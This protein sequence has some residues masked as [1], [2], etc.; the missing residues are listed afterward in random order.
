MVKDLFA[1]SKYAVDSKESDINTHSFV[2][3]VDLEIIEN[4]LQQC[5]LYCFITLQFQNPIQD[6]FLIN[7]IDF[8]IMLLDQNSQVLEQYNNVNE[9]TS[10]QVDIHIPLKQKMDKLFLKLK[11]IDNGINQQQISLIQDTFQTVYARIENTKKEEFYLQRH[12]QLILTCPKGQFENNGFCIEC[13]SCSI[14]NS[15]ST[16]SAQ[17]ECFLCLSLPPYGLT[18]RLDGSCQKDCPPGLSYNVWD[19]Q[20][21]IGCDQS[22][23]VCKDSKCVSC[24]NNSYMIYPDFNTCYL[25]QNGSTQIGNLCFKCNLNQFI[26]L[27]NKKCSS[28]DIYGPC[29]KCDQNQCLKCSPS[30]CFDGF[31]QKKCIYPSNEILKIGDFCFKKSSS[32]KSYSQQSLREDKKQI[33]CDQCVNSKYI[34]YYDGSCQ[35]TCK[36]WHEVFDGVCMQCNY[37]C[38][39]CPKIYECNRCEKDR[40]VVEDISAC[41]K[42][43][44]CLEMPGHFINKISKT[45]DVCKIDKGYYYS[46][47]QCK[48]C[49]SSCK[50]CSGGQYNQCLTCFEGSTLLDDKTCF[51]CTINDGKYIDDSKNCKQCHYSCKTCNGGSELNCLTCKGN[52]ILDNQSKRCVC[53]LSNCIECSLDGFSCLKCK[54]GYVGRDCSECNIAQGKYIFNN[55]CKSCDSSCQTCSGPLKTDCIDCKIQAFKVD[56]INKLCQCT[57]ENCQ[58][59][60]LDGIECIKCIDGYTLK[61]KKCTFCDIQNGYFISPE[62]ICQECHSS[63]MKCNGPYENNCEQCKQSG[64]ILD[65]MS[66]KCICKFKNCLECSIDGLHCQKCIENYTIRNNECIYCDLYNGYYLEN[67]VC[68]KCDESCSSCTGPTKY[69]CIRCAWGNYILDPK[70]SLCICGIQNCKT[71]SVMSCAECI[72]DFVLIDNKC[73]FCDLS[74]SKFIL[75]NNCYQCH[76]S[77]KTCHGPTER[78]CDTCLI[79]L[80]ERDPNNNNICSCTI[81]NCKSC[82]SDG[83]KCLECQEFYVNQQNF[84]Q[85]CDEKKGYQFNKISNQCEKCHESCKTCFGTQKTEC[86][87]CIKPNYKPNLSNMNIC[88]CALQNCKMCDEDGI[89]CLQCQM[90]YYQVNG[91]CQYCDISQFN[92]DQFNQKC[93]KCHASCSTCNGPTER[94]CIKCLNDNFVQDPLNFNICNCK[95]KNCQ[96]CSIDGAF[97]QKCSEN[98]YLSNSKTECFQCDI[99]NQFF[100]DKQENTCLSCHGDCKT[101]SGTQKNECLSCLHKGQF[102]NESNFCVCPQN[103]CLKCE[104]EEITSKKICQCEQCQCD[105]ENCEQC[106]SQDEETC[107]V[108]KPNFILIENGKVCQKQKYCKVE[109]CLQCSLNSDKICLKCQ[110]GFFLSENNRF[111]DL[112]FNEINLSQQFHLNMQLTDEGYK[113]ILQFEKPLLIR[114]ENNFDQII[115]VQITQI[116]REDY[117][118]KIKKA[119]EKQL[120]IHLMLNVTCKEERGILKIKDEGFIQLNYLSKTEETVVLENFVKLNQNQKEQQKNI[121]VASQSITSTVVG[122]VI[123]LALLGNF[124]I[125]FSMLDITGLIYYLLY[126]DI[127]YPFNVTSFCSL[128]QNFQ[129]AFIPNMLLKFLDTNYVQWAPKKFI[130]NESDGY[131]LHGAGQ[132]FTIITI[133]MVIYTSLKILQLI[134]IKSFNKYITEK[135]RGGWEYSGFIDLIGTVYLY[136]LVSV[137]LQVYTFE[138]Y[139]NSSQINYI[140]FAIC[141]FAVFAIPIKFTHIIYKSKNAKD[142]TFLNQRLGS[143]IGGLKLF[144]QD[145]QIE[146]QDIQNQNEDQENINEKKNQKTK[147]SQLQLIEEEVCDKTIE[148]KIF[149]P[150]E[151]YRSQDGNI[152]QSQNLNIYEQQPKEGFCINSSKCVDQFK[153]TSN[154]FGTEKYSSANLLNKKTKRQMLQ[155]KFSKYTNMLLYFRKIIFSCIV[156]YLHDYTYVQVCLLSVLSLFV[157]AY[158]LYV[159]PQVSNF[160]NIKNGVSELILII[161]IFSAGLLKDDPKEQNEEER[162]NIGW[163]FVSC[164]AFIIMVQ[165]IDLIIELFKSLLQPILSLCRKKA[166][167]TV[168]SFEQ[169]AK[170]RRK[171]VKQKEN[172][173]SEPNNIQIQQNKFITSQINLKSIDQIGKYDEQ[174]PPNLGEFPNSATILEDIT[175]SIPMNPRRKRIKFFNTQNE[176]QQ[177]QV[178]SIKP[179][180]SNLNVNAQSHDSIAQIYDQNSNIQPNSSSRSYIQDFSSGQFIKS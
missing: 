163:I 42:E 180:N 81:K 58:T 64:F 143:L 22:Q 137:L 16:Y 148:I 73:V 165:A 30:A 9:L 69:D 112:T 12:R 8:K 53:N 127:R 59:C 89:T 159:M 95:I 103:T 164:T 28:C 124:Y 136:V 35:E 169:K 105:I 43:S 93:Y 171:S 2:F 115:E 27:P 23:C 158:Y 113:I 161:I 142:D 121:Q 170:K 101:C 157:G 34:K 138:I 55:I 5:N 141:S 145:D 109:N 135:I 76:E 87:E 15:L 96:Q 149:S 18:Q 86:Y 129:F 66:K 111:C 154:F 168:P 3:E 25:C 102:L 100:I 19:L 132:S 56:P 48:K 122:T 68:K 91:I 63:C 4:K 67:G 70:T 147:K 133:F 146:F 46:D 52:L 99:Q 97:C 1:S 139:D 155:I 71:C 57:I 173:I 144:N 166:A 41:A 47:G 128:F 174:N 162:I 110:K 51:T 54:E 7:N 83:S 134:P 152:L 78:D 106:I 140:L 72:E 84:C 37:D 62:N 24:L 176:K 98:F 20:C 156:V 40:F 13:S 26:D 10:K 90:N 36:E 151:S 177:L 61:D 104:L 77:C 160:D 6:H 49:H 31:D 79:P 167:K 107:E 94:D 153:Q 38:V 44:E 82:N 179:R 108:C 88:E 29:E 178:I 175:Q 118:Y 119:S 172:F 150:K 80:F 65:S 17:R 32:C 130:E 21:T 126:L 123:P 39:K 117:S 11:Y 50:T 131:F 60:D 85:Y 125:V 45:C 33:V 75:N 116:K 14:C 74:Q 120:K 92:Y 114:D